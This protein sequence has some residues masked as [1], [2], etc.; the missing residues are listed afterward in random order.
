MSD[1]SYISVSREYLDAKRAYENSTERLM[2]RFNASAQPHPARLPVKPNMKVGWKNHYYIPWVP[3]SW[4]KAAMS[5]H[6]NAFARYLAAYL[7]Y[8]GSLPDAPA[9]AA[10]KAMDLAAEAQR[11]MLPGISEDL[12]GAAKA[13]IVDWCKSAVQAYRRHPSKEN[14]KQLFVTAVHMG[15]LDW[16]VPELDAVLP[17]AHAHWGP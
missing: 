9:A 17:A 4:D 2:R 6:V 14:A 3:D 1:T 10:G 11:A 16:S 15:F 5:L 13:V 12:M 7:A 8:F